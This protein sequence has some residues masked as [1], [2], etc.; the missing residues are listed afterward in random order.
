MADVTM[1]DAPTAGAAKGKAAA[2]SEGKD[3][4]EKKR[5]EVKKVCWIVRSDTAP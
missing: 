2:K 1:S 5:F 3:S 4:G